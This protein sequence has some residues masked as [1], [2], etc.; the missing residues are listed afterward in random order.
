MRSGRPRVD[1]SRGRRLHVAAPALY[2]LV[3]FLYFGL[4]PLVDA[5]PSYVGSGPDP[6]IFIW[7]FAWWPHALLHGQNPFV[8]HAI[9]APGGINL[10]WA[11]TVPGLALLF[12]PLTL[13]RGPASSPTTSPPS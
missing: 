7:S 4:R 8:T 5:G 11:T 12:A 10:A 1:L 13:A 6:Q 2:G 9:W 3:S